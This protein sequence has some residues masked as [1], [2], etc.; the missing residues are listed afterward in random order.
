MTENTSPINQNRSASMNDCG[1]TCYQINLQRTFGGGEVYTHFFSKALQTLGRDVVLFTSR[2]AS[3]WYDLLMDGVHIVP[4]VNT[5]EIIEHLPQHRSLIVA[6]APVQGK[7]LAVLR[8]HRYCC[9]AHMPLFERQPDPF[10]HCDVILG[11]SQYVL[12]TL[13]NKGLNNYYPEPLYGVADLDRNRSQ[14]GRTINKQP[15]YDWDQRKVRDR[16][17]G[18]VYPLFWPLKRK[19]HFERRNDLTIGIVSRI[20]T[21]KQFPL[22]FSIIAPIIARYPGVS[23]EIFGSGGYASVRDLERS[24]RPIRHQVR[25]WGRQDNVAEIYRQ[26]DF[27][28]TGLPEK[29]ALG[30][31]I[32]EA[33]T[34]CTPVL[35][36]RAPPFTETVLDGRTGLLYT[37]PRIDD[38]RDFERVLSALL[39]G[40][41]A[42]DPKREIAHLRRFSFE[43][44][45]ER[46]Q[47]ALNE[48][49]KNQT[50]SGPCQKSVS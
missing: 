28:M 25:F 41:K 31:N 3:F 15:L 26:L 13:R 4:V 38:G 47:K 9:F 6:H 32:I 45:V 21:I 40:M 44:F 8:K 1:G 22:L 30:L 50:L 14:A 42:P 48:I 11:V 23:I 20:T 33:Q 37:D 18:L 2:H 35:A 29:E 19:Q 17:L 27:V 10:R 16:L 34:C 43:N 5:D 39:R 49:T 12:E 36:V 24:L 46:V 7:L